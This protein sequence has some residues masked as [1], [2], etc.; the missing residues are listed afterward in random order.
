MCD[1]FQQVTGRYT[2]YIPFDKDVYKRAEDMTRIH[3]NFRDILCELVLKEIENMEMKSSENVTP[4]IRGL[5]EEMGLYGGKSFRDIDLFDKYRWINYFL[6]DLL[7]MIKKNYKQEDHLV[8][9]R[10]EIEEDEELLEEMKKYIDK[11]V[12]EEHPRF[13]EVTRFTDAIESVEGNVRGRMRS[14]QILDQDYQVTRGTFKLIPMEIY[15]LFLTCDVGYGQL[16]WY[17]NEIM[18]Y[19]DCIYQEV[20]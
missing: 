3:Q 19:L 10:M 11:K 7:L 2:E 12:G 4:T 18:A 1:Y 9:C 20:L 8:L 15:A 16:H 14:Y 17:F 5:S 6:K 13:K